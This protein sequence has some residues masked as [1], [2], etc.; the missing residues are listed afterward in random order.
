MKVL[1]TGASGLVGKALTALP[2][3]EWIGVSS[4]DA[5]LREVGEVR[6]LF[7]KHMPFDG[8]IHLAANVGGV[9]KN[10]AQPVEMYE[11]NM[12]MNTNVLRVAH[13]CDIRRVM[14]YLSTCIFPDPAPGYPMTADML[15]TGPPHPS[16]QG[17]AY[18]KRMVDIH[19]RAYRQQYGREYFCVVPTNIYGPYD[20]FDLK[21]AHV[22]PALIHKCYLAQRDGTPFVIAGD[23]TPQRQFIYS[24]DIARL[25]LWAYQNYTAL[26]QPMIFCPPDAEVP[27]AHVA[28][29]ITK[30][31]DFKGPVTYDTTRTNGQLKKTAEST[32]IDFVYTPLEEGIRRTVEWFTSAEN[33]RL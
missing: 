24:D 1:V 30:A 25:T 31:F 9:F 19:C 15:H 21:D 17:Y 3:V 12:L 4:S 2:G 10:M 22:I 20:N 13:E 5:D 6:A 7:K 26:D 14:C 23:G 32:T 8:I 27:L 16:N 33:K 28:S 11:D 29:L 18:A